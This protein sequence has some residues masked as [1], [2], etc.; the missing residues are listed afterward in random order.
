MQYR[1]SLKLDGKLPAHALMWRRETG[2]RDKQPHLRIRKKP[3][4]NVEWVVKSS[5]KPW[6]WMQVSAGRAQLARG[7]APERGCPGLGP[8]VSSH[9]LMDTLPPASACGNVTCAECRR[10]GGG[11]RPAWRAGLS[12]VSP[13][14]PA[15]SQSCFPA[16][17]RLLAGPALLPFV[18]PSNDGREYLE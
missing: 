1:A 3:M 8:A 6:C 7:L 18:C 15:L 12:P 16:T 4:L 17:E 2:K 5:S 9:Y 14:H 11:G 10:T 13:A